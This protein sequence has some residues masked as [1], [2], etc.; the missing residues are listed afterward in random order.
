MSTI[1]SYQQAISWELGYK[2]EKEGRVEKYIPATVPGAVQL[3]WAV[4]EGF[5]PYWYADNYKDYLWMEDCFWV[6]RTRFEQ[7]ELNLNQRVFFVSKGID[8]QFDIIL[9][10]NL[11]HQQQG[12]FAPVAIDI[13]SELKKDNILE[14]QIYPAPKLKGA[15]HGRW[16]AAHSVKPAVSYGW[17]WHPRL[18]PLGIWDETYLEIRPQSHVQSTD[19][20]YQLSADFKKAEVA[21]KVQGEHL[22]GVAF[23]FRFSDQAGCV[24]AHIEGVFDG[25]FFV[26]P[27]VIDNPELW[28]PH[29]HGPQNLYDWVIE[30][31][32]KDA[33]ILFK[34]EKRVGFRHVQLVMNEGAWDEP[35]DFPK[36]RS[37][38]PITLQINGRRIFAKGT[39]WVNPEIFPGVINRTRYNELLDFCVQANFNLIRVWGGGIV[40]KESFFDLCDQKGLMVWQEFPLACN[41]Y[42]NDNQYLSVLKQE[43]AA[44]IHRVRQHPCLVMWCGGNELF[45]VW[46]MMT[47]QHLALRLLNSQCYLLDPQTPF[48]PTSPVM[49]MG[50]GHYVFRDL[51]TKEE[52]YTI[53]NRARCTAYTEFG[54]PS[55]SSADIIKKIIPPIEL[56]PPKPGTAWETHHAFNA[57]VGD[58]WLMRDLIEE[59]FGKSKLL[60]QLVMNGQIIQSE[61][62]KAI[63][64]E[65][66]RQKPY[67]SMALNWCFNEPWPTAANNSLIQWPNIPKPAFK[68]VSDACRPVMASARNHRFVWHEGE[69]FQADLFIL[70]DSYKK[71]GGG[72]LVAKL[73][74]GPDE[75]I[76]LR[77]DFDEL[78]LNNNLV[79]PTVR[80]KLPHLRTDRF[81][82]VLQ[83]IDR[84]EMNSEYLFMFRPIKTKQHEPRQLNQ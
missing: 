60:E 26:L 76:M 70:N 28:W 52:V 3:D 42:P 19:F 63:Y 47:D 35:N 27:F 17:D 5:E 72:T 58:T 39:N 51:T 9:N 6:Y 25:D 33:N 16:E 74:D 57:W 14:V 59:Y 66:R 81:K 32:D 12:M 48:L 82:L 64:E 53:M 36:S 65:A 40:N 83:V 15:P 73:V 45:N 4:E 75:Y 7:P 8:Y 79:G 56:W 37:T 23:R 24:M 43:S 22:S 34:K 20:T 61:G 2:K 44:I 62:Y 38:A 1:S 50:H 18:I 78:P 84:P 49:G 71:T 67:C 69:V 54:M 68:A 31:I 77:W 55:P 21:I 29:D 11:V 46:S 13:T 80:F 41:E 10:G 30:F